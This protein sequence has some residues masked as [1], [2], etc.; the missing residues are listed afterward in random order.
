MITVYK[1]DR[2]P[3]LPITLKRDG[4]PVDLSTASSVNLRLVNLSTGALKFSTAAS[5]IGASTGEVT[6]SWGATDLDTA[7]E[8]A[9]KAQITWGVGVTETFDT[10]LRLE[11]KELEVAA[12]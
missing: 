9:V 10:G 1:N 4:G 3:T 5:I 7:G 8:Y 12:P 11:V 2:K 6:Y